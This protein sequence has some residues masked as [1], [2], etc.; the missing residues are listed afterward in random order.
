MELTKVTFEYT[1]GE[2][3]YLDGQD[4]EDWMKMN[5]M[6]ASCAHLHGI[7][8]DWKSIKWKKIGI[9]PKY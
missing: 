3:K 5:S 4:L 6:V 7:K 8:P 9:D 2:R 1:N